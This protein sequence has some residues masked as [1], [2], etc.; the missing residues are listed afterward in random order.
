M[1]V[2]FLVERNVYFRVFG[3]IIDEAIKMGHQV[4]C[5]HNY[6]QSRSGS[7]G[8]QFPDISQTP[9][10]QNGKVFSLD[11][12]TEN[13]LIEK[14]FQNNIQAI[15]SLEFSEIYL[16]IKNKLKEQRIFWFALQS[17]FDTGSS[18]GKYLS[19]PD[20]FFI[21]SLEW[22]KW[23]FEYLKKTGE[24]KEE[25]FLAFGNKLQEKIKTV[26]FWL[27]EQKNIIDKEKIKKEWGISQD[28]KVVLLLPFPFG[29][30]LK[31]FWTKYIYGT[32]FFSKQNDFEVSKTIRRF[33][34]NNNAFLLV[35]CRKKDPARRYLTKIAD[36]V[37]YDESFYPSTTMECLSVA[38]ICF[39]FYS[40]GAIEAV[41]MGVP[42][43]CIAPD[44][45]KW[46]DIQSV[47][48]Q[49]ILAKE[50]DFFDLQGASYL[51]TIPEII[52][53]LPKQTF[54]DFYFSK[55]SQA[56]YLQKFAN[57]NIETASENIISEIEKLIK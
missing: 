16:S 4:F 55:E 41:S 53:N 51:K 44:V 33:C 38:D 13:E 19:K 43:V 11:Y 7:K 6:N 28:K 40:T 24:A 21:Y 46:K 10:F 42:N 27:A 17:G 32:R 29:S 57:A 8:Y 52:N 14:V 9:K 5:L 20:K 56:R 3:P 37:I 48:W 2:A 54:A 26:G 50:K 31:T 30:S 18:S 15:V 23:M 1:N 45:K 22:L 49:T 39:N 36:K 25:N 34:D 35:K 12:K 47:L